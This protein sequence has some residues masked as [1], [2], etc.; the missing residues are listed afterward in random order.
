MEDIKRKCNLTEDLSK[1]TFNKKI[2]SKATIN[3]VAKLF[4]PF[5]SLIIKL[6]ILYT[7]NTHVK[8]CVNQILF[9]I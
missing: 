7:F 2:L 8:F 9:I 5:E 4:Y 1:F 6:H 3:F